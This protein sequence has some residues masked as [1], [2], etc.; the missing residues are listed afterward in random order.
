M[1]F[2]GRPAAAIRYPS[3][4]YVQFKRCR[5]LAQ[6]KWLVRRWREMAR[7]WGQPWVW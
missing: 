6:R 1:Q 5:T 7:E 3:Q 4:F 2:I